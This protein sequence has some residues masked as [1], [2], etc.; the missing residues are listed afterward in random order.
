MDLDAAKMASPASTS[1]EQL[2]GSC[3]DCQGSGF[4][5]I[6]GVPG[7]VTRC[8][9]RVKQ[10]ALQYLTPLYASATWNRNLNP[11]ALEGRN[12]L[13]EN[14]GKVPSKISPKAFC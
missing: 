9:C 5:A 13:L 1:Q 4:I 12:V 6:S 2:L 7:T 10:E 3:P 11:S 8:A 14:Y